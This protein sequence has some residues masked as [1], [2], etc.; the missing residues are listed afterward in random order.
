MEA[1]FFLP[2]ALLTEGNKEHIVGTGPGA[3]A[4][5]CPEQ[6]GAV[7]YLLERPAVEPERK[8]QARDMVRGRCGEWGCGSRATPRESDMAARLA[9]AV[10][11]A[12]RP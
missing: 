3:G 12:D 7:G 1:V 5:R 9:D 10:D 2:Q 11:D 6:G 8:R 4:G